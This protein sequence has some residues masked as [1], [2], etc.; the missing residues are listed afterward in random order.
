MEGGAGEL[1]AWLE[2]DRDHLKTGGIR[3]T[4]GDYRCLALGHLARVAIFRLNSSWKQSASIE[5]RIA[6]ARSALESLVAESHVDRIVAKV[7]NRP[8]ASPLPTSR[9]LMQARIFD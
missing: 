7:A 8:S 2:A 5:S 3:C 9:E 6:L 4:E 1:A